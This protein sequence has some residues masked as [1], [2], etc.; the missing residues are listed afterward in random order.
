MRVGPHLALITGHRRELALQG[1]RDVDPGVRD[2]APRVAPLGAARRVEGV[3]RL[4]VRLRGPGGDEQRLEEQLVVPVHV[5]AVL[6]VDDAR[7]YLAH[8]LLDGAD[9]LGERDRVQPL[10]GETQLAHV[11]DAERLGRAPHVI[12][13]A[14]PAR[15]IAERFAFAGDDGHHR[16]SP[17][18]VE[19]DRAAASQ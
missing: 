13:L 16:V 1:G 8:D 5:A 4:D 7:T 11:P 12:G 19:C 2:E 10:V 18:G 15:P 17:L 3:H 14:H 9:Q 6:P